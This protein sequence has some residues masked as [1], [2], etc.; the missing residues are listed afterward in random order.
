[1][2]EKEE[3]KY[4]KK[5]KKSNSSKL[6]DFFIIKYAPLVKYVAGKVACNIPH[7]IEFDDLVGFGTFG[8][9]DAIEKF[10]P[11]KGIKFKTY[12]ITRIRGAIYD[13]LRTL[14]WVPRS[15]RQKYKQMD[16]ISKQF[17]ED[18]KRP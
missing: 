8:L 11:E 1:M 9:I 16:E 14:D 10:D 17:E 12:G 3:I 2:T 18:K 6:K 7:N 15:V 4:W 13:E 5:F